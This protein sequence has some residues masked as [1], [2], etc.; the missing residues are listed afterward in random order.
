VGTVRFTQGQTNVGGHPTQISEP[1][2]YDFAF[3]AQAKY[4]FFVPISGVCP[5]NVPQN[6][7]TPD[8][9]HGLGT[10]FR[11]FS[12]PRSLATTEDNNFHITDLQVKFYAYKRAF[13]ALFSFAQMQMILPDGTIVVYGAER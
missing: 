7:S 4:E 6:R 5:H 9:N 3:I 12:Q 2:L 8:R 11:L 13:N 1:V 10:V